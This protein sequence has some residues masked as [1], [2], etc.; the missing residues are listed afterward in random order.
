MRGGGGCRVV[1]EFRTVRLDY[2][3]TANARAHPKATRNIVA[4]VEICVRPPVGS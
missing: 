1:K 2:L 3:G 4:I